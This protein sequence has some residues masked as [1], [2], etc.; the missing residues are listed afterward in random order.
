MDDTRQ[1]PP[2]SDELTI[3]DLVFLGFKSQ[4][5]ALD[6]YS[7]DV[8]WSWKSPKGRSGYVALLV[9]DDRLIVSVQGYTYCLDPLN[10]QLVWQNPLSGYGIGIPSLASV[11]GSSPSGAAVA[12]VMADAQRRAAAGGAAPG[13]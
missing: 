11:H 4:V 12:A 2:E 5:V 7:G 6:R 10:G 9:D 1:A 13:V 3:L 8:V